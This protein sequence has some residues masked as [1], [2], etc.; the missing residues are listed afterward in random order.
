MYKGQKKNSA[1]DFS[2]KNASSKSMELHIYR[3]VKKKIRILYSV[4]FL[5]IK[6]KEI[7]FGSTKAEQIHL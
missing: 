4:I 5:K 2:L 1:G 6:V 7:F 3:N